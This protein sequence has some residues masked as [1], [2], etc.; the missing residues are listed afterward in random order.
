MASRLQKVME[1]TD[2]YNLYWEKN[3]HALKHWALKVCR[4]DVFFSG[5]IPKKTTG[6]RLNTLNSHPPHLSQPDMSTST[7]TQRGI[8]VG[9]IAVN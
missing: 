5:K 2:L 1:S 3:I 8:Q 4:K 9:F 6:S 7:E